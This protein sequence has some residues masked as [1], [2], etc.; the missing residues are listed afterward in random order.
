[1]ASRSI[2]LLLSIASSRLLRSRFSDKCKGASVPAK[3]WFQRTWLS[4]V[5]VVVGLAMLLL[6]WVT[7]TSETWWAGVLV[8]AGVTVMLLVPLL[9]VTGVVERQFRGV[10]ESQVEIEARQAQTSQ[11]IK[12]IAADVAATQDQVRRTRDEL[13]ETMR[14]RLSNRAAAEQAAVDALESNPTMQSTREALKQATVLGIIH[15][16]GICVPVG[17]GVPLWFLPVPTENPLA[18]WATTEDFYYP[19]SVLVCRLGWDK[20]SGKELFWNESQSVEE[21]LETLALT[22]RA[23]DKYPGDEAFAKQAPLVALKDVLGRALDENR[24][25][26]GSNL[27]KI[28][29]YM[30]TRWIITDNGV[31]NISDPEDSWTGL[32][33]IKEILDTPYQERNE[34]I[35][36]HLPN[37]DLAISRRLTRAFHGGLADAAC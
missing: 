22:L 31:V 12:Q 27:R 16:G 36:R 7:R 30:P 11:Q 35:M 26:M 1:M 2:R 10:R 3:R 13:A 23:I 34:A 6:S 37:V 14:E 17:G 24:Q 5:L 33:I 25:G 19:D 18:V 4:V 15:P 20:A 32:Y 28:I 29:M 9:L 8:E 21:F